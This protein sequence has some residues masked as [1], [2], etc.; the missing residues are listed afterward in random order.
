MDRAPY[1]E[2]NADLVRAGTVCL[3]LVTG[4]F[5][6]TEVACEQS[7]YYYRGITKGP[8]L[9]RIWPRVS[10]YGRLDFSLSLAFG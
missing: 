7:H 8:Q 6:L 2:L 5:I 10:R 4:T 3:G 9:E 1:F